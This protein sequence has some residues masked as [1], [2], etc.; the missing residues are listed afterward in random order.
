MSFDFN[1]MKRYPELLELHYLGEQ[2]R[3]N[4]LRSIFDRDITNNDHF[5]YN[6]CRIYPIKNEGK[7]DLDREF[8]H[9][10]TE[11]IEITNKDGSIIKRRVYDAYHSERLH[12][13]KYHIEK[14]VDDSN[15]LVFSVKERNFQ[16]RTPII[17]TYIYNKTRKYVI[18][19][20]PQTRSNKAA[21]YLLTA[22]YL[23]KTYG[24]KQIEKKLK[25][26]LPD[27]L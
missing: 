13:I 2:E 14:E 24:E 3:I 11:E 26:K 15:I 23:N 6:D 27:V 21:Y 12:W 17:R 8:T 25:A 19:L 5:Y 18:V 20:E 1:L 16:K 7:L 4:S 10:T 22:Y 9:L